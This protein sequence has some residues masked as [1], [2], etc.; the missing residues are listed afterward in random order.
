MVNAGA[1][2]TVTPKIT[3]S[4]G[5]GVGAAATCEIVTDY[6]GLTNVSIANSGFGYS[7]NP[8]V[9][10]SSPSVGPA[11]TA[12]VKST[13]TQTNNIDQILISNAGVGYTVPPSVTINAPPLLSGI[14]TY[15]SNEVVIGSISGTKSRVKS[16]F[17]DTKV[18]QVGI[19]TGSF[20]SGELITGQSSSAVYSLKYY[21]KA[22]YNDKYQQNDEIEIESDLTLD[23]SEKNPFGNY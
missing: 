14:G 17:A 16:W 4:G 2:Y 5:D 22:D 6:Y 12:T 10:I 23:F 13:L 7:N 19:T 9:T 21:D 15:Q 3:I 1:G 18:L 8:I 11:I 20:V